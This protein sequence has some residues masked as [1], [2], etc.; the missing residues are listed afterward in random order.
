MLNIIDLIIAGLVLFYFL[1]NA[2]G[3]V[4]TIKNILIFLVILILFGVAS[5][6]LLNSAFISGD[7]RKTLEDAYF[8]KLSHALINWSYPAVQ[9]NAPKVDSFIQENIITSPT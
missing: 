1:K 7:A 2:G 9:D 8:V 4:K 5:R 6:L 3:V